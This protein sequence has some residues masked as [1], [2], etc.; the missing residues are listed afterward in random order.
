MGTKWDQVGTTWDQ[1]GTTWDQLGSSTVKY[2]ESV[3]L[4]NIFMVF[5][6]VQ[7]G[8]HGMVGDWLLE[9]GNLCIL[10]RNRDRRGYRSRIYSAIGSEASGRAS[11]GVSCG[12]MR[13]RGYRSRI[14]RVI[15]S[16]ALRGGLLG[17]ELWGYAQASL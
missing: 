10:I 7:G 11:W 4:L 5:C 9:G 15:G 14:Y 17:S 16:E 12:D 8:D 1:V 3:I 2:A 13:R 6:E